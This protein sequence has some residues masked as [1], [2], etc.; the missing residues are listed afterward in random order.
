MTD[1]VT[2]GESTMLSPERI[3]TIV[4]YVCAGEYIN[5]AKPEY[6]VPSDK[7]VSDLI[8]RLMFAKDRGVL[9]VTHAL[10]VDLIRREVLKERYVPLAE[11]VRI[12]E[13]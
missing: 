6:Y 8:H 9:E 10:A 4:S 2:S 3:Q 7:L 5:G 13:A 12:G 1:K 11:A